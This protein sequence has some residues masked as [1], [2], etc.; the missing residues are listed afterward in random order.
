MSDDPRRGGT[1]A[2]SAPFDDLCHGR[3]LAQKGMVNVERDDAAFGTA[4]HKALAKRDPSKLT[5][6]QIDIY[7]SCVGIEDKIVDK[8]FGPA[9]GQC[10][11]FRET[12]FYCKVKAR[13]SDIRFDHSAQPDV[14][15]RHGPQGLVIEYKTLVG[16]VATSAENLQLRDQVVLAA[17]SLVMNEVMAVVIQPLVTH[18]PT[19]TLY[20]EVSIKQAEEEMWERVRQSNDPNSKRTAGE[21]QCQF[22]LAKPKC[23]EYAKW[24]VAIVP[25]TMSLPDI[26]VAEWSIE[27]RVAFCQGYTA[28]EKWIDY[29]KEAMK[30]LMAADPEAV[31]GFYLKPGKV[32]EVVK[33][34][35]ALFE[36]F[37]ELG[38]TQA[39]FLACITVGKE[40]LEEQTRAITGKVG[41]G[42]TAEVKK[43]LDGI[44]EK[45]PPEAPSI[46]QKKP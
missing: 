31:P 23:P 9:R 35:E 36:R 4:V 45:K 28:V 33:D 6:E 19:P 22:C 41:K 14:V 3:H 39:Q 11:Q 30:L 5:T 20:D 40:K 37:V 25:V 7:E 29:N 12:R 44:V 26:P 8:L 32:R 17:R 43:L 46:A 18:D 1:S 2:S 15:Y 24:S 27:H 10:K 34:P 38:G 16:D 13:D 21:K 42:L